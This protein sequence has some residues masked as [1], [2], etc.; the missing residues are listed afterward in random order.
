MRK[1]DVITVDTDSLVSVHHDSIRLSPF[2]SGATQRPN[3][4]ERGEHN[5]FQIE[6]YPFA[7]R[8]RQ[9]GRRLPSPKSPCSA[10]FTT[11]PST[12]STLSAIEVQQ[13]STQSSNRR[14]PR[15]VKFGS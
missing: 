2:N 4:P 6:D 1:H 3:A 15:T 11:W 13:S 9:T 12:Y 10:A 14:C 7:E 5:F 8:V